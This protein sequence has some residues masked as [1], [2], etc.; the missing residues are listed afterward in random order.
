MAARA[1]TVG[2]EIAKQY[3]YSSAAA[4]LIK[5]GWRMTTALAEKHPVVAT[6]LANLAFL[7]EDKAAEVIADMTTK[8]DS[9]IVPLESLVGDLVV[10]ENLQN[11]LADSI[12]KVVGYD[13]FLANVPGKIS[14]AIPEN[15]KTALKELMERRRALLDMESV[16]RYEPTATD[17]ELAVETLNVIG[18]YF[19]ARSERQIIELHRALR[20]FVNTSSDDIAETARLIEIIR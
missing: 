13:K 4:N 3:G 1:I 11:V 18:N 16:V 12:A 8:T 6:I 10:D 19:G 2:Y 7:G 17:Q 5:K 15:T 9:D 20:A 14:R